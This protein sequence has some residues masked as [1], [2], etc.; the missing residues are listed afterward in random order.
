[1]S[2]TALCGRMR[3]PILGRTFIQSSK[4]LP[5]NSQLFTMGLKLRAETETGVLI[6]RQPFTSS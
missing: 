3:L 5:L 6:L 2:N 4:R 1:M